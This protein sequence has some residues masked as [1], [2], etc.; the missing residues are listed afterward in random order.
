MRCALALGLLCAAA[1]A[2]WHSRWDRAKAL[3]QA[4][5]KPLLLY[6]WDQN[7]RCAALHGKTP[8]KFQRV[9]SDF[10]LAS[11]FS[12]GVP[13][14]IAPHRVAT[15]QVFSSSFRDSRRSSS[16]P[17]WRSTKATSPS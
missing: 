16:L 4:Q 3:S 13:R 2:Q 9:A 14:N 8:P 1:S 7:A 15:I 6:T 17:I 10:V 5:N 12:R 11:V